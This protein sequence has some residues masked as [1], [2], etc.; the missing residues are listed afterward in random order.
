VHV[1]PVE[2]RPADLAQVSLDLRSRAAAFAGGI[3]QEIRTGMRAD[4]N[5]NSA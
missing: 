5:C 3:A 2:Q 4:N 1:D